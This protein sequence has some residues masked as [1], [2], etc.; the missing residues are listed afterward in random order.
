VNGYDYILVGGGLQNGLLALALRH[1]QPRTRVALV[2]ASDRLGGN[3]TWCFHAADV[4]PEAAAMIEPLTVASWSGY[5]TRFPG[6][7]RTVAS[8]YAAATSDRFAV[9]VRG[10]VEAC[11]WDLRLGSRAVEVGSDFVT[12]ETG[13]RLT[14][15]CVI[16]ARGPREASEGCG[17]QKFFGSEVETDGWP[18]RVPVVMDATVPQTDGFHFVY[19]VPLTATRVL[20]EDTYFSD[21]P[22][23]DRDTARQQVESYLRER[24]G[25]WRVV[26]EESGVLPMPWRPERRPNG[27]GPLLG[28]YAGGWFHPATGYSFPVALRFALAVASVPP[29]GATR[30]ASELARR[31][32]FRWRFARFLNLLLFR[33][34]APEARWQVFAR[35]YRTLPPS[36]LARFYA[37]EFS[38]ADAARMVVGRPPRIDLLRPLRRPGSKSWLLRSP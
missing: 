9:V 13:E 23:L 18:D 15:R 24:V 28:G 10:A 26:R 22:D 27:N 3:H 30:A 34:V 1:F 25:G 17:Y 37:L 36:V 14:G 29:E 31:L 38:A 6:H 12:L 20:V 2:E 5:E 8:R 35:L 21:T 32:R 33:L 7:S 19:T 4:P 16:D 11:G